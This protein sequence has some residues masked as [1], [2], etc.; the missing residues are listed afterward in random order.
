M[1]RYITYPGQALAFMVGRLELERLRREA[2]ARLHGRF[3]VRAFHD[4]VLRA[5]PLPLA[6]MAGV[7]GRWIE[8]TEGPAA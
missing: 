7:V 1:N 2:A 5:G 3:S 8:S 6:A 4:V